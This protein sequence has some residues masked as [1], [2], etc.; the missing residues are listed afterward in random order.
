[1]S[2]YRKLRVHILPYAK[3]SEIVSSQRDLFGKETMQ[4]RIAAPAE[5]G[6]ANK[7]LVRFLAR[8]FSVAKSNVSIVVGEFARDKIVQLEE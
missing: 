8:H 1:M 2:I 4:I 6:K 7:E 5:D 3:K